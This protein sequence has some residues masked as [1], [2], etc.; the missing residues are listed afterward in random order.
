LSDAT[1]K[2]KIVEVVLP[3][4]RL[5]RGRMEQLGT[6][7]SRYGGLDRVEI[8]V[9]SSTG[10][11][12]RMALPTRVDAHNGLMLAEVSDIIGRE[13]NVVLV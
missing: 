1:N 2:P 12:M 5:S 9:R 11:T 7:F 3:S 8:L 13:G 6:V 4:N 10:D